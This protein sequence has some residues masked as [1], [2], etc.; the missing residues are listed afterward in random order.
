VVDNVDESAVGQWRRRVWQLERV[1]DWY[2]QRIHE[3]EAHIAGDECGD[4]VRPPRQAEPVEVAETLHSAS[5]LY[6]ERTRQ[7]EIELKAL[8]SQSAEKEKVIAQLATASA[9][10]L[11]TIGDL[12]RAVRDLRAQLA[13]KEAVI[14]ELS[15]ACAERQA[16]INALSQG[17]A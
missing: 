6:F 10:R 12:D 5:A 15:A 17:Y 4:S 14:A 11:D 2:L 7:F 13:E 16:V 8:K 9:E 1:V 3:L